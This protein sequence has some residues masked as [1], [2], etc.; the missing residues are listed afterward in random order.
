VIASPITPQPATTPYPFWGLQTATAGPRQPYSGRTPGPEAT[1]L[2]FTYWVQ[3]GDTLSALAARFGISPGQISAAQSLP[4][5]GL[6]LPDLQLTIPNV[7][8]DLPYPSALLPDSAI[9][10]SP[11]AAGFQVETFVTQAGGYLSTYLEEVDTGEWL[12]GPEIVQRVA[13]ETSV[14]PQL[15]LTFLEYRSH[16]VLGQ[17]ADPAQV[18]YPIGFYV[19]DYLGLYKELSLVAKMLNI[20]YYG[21]RQGTFVELEFPDHSHIRLSPGLNA[22]SVALQSLVSKFYSQKAWLDTLYGPQGLLV[23]FNELFGDP[24]QTAA[25]IGPLFPIGLA[26][27]TLELPFVPGQLWK[28]T[29][30]PHTA[31]TTGTPRGALDFAPITAEPP[32][33]ISTAWAAASA[34]GLVVRSERGV[35]ALDLDGDGLEQTGWVLLYMHLAEV[36]RIALGS[37]VAV[38]TPLGH[39]SCEG[40]ATT[41]RHV[42][43]TRKYNGEWLAADGPLPLVLSGWVAHAGESPFDGMLKKDGQIVSAPADGSPGSTIVR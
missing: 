36:E 11:A 38:D 18:A 29:A 9:I 28:L 35:V 12:S 13:L 16:W 23:L 4:T 3:P 32:C 1:L 42:H 8:G 2:P 19:P 7:L 39:P 33:A 30:G 15:L 6:L 27:P 31:W 34:P 37:W 10:Y 43:L 17:P 21:W 24:W 25:K 5:D 20:G 14:N 26:Q 40:G 41:G 22:G